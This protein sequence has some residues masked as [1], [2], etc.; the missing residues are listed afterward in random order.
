MKKMLTMLMCLLLAVTMCA[1]AL[2]VDADILSRSMLGEETYA[3][4]VSM[5]VV[6]ETMYV[7][8]ET[9]SSLRLA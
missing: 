1:P 8:L 4:P 7:L 9:A 6:G 2:A 3:S 5:T